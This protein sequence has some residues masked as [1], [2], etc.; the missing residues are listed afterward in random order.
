MNNGIDLIDRLDAGE[1]IDDIMPY[2]LSGF[3]QSLRVQVLALYA[4]YG[5]DPERRAICKKKWHD[6]LE[7]RLTDEGRTESL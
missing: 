3:S 6:I 2:D 1:K 5:E 7:G 4:T